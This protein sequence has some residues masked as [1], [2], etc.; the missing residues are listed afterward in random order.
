MCV[1]RVA[2]DTRFDSNFGTP[3]GTF[4]ASWMLSTWRSVTGTRIKSK[5]RTRA[6]WL[7]WATADDLTIELE[8]YKFLQRLEDSV[9]LG[10]FYTANAMQWVI[11]KAGTYKC[12]Q[13]L[14]DVKNVVS[15]QVSL[16]MFFSLFSLLGI[17]LIEYV[18]RSSEIWV[19]GLV[20]H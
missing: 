18:L 14:E 20:L 3:D 10:V 2:Y 19:V 15:K 1:S 8:A 7:G 4:T 6:D 11:E 17:S 12:S 5:A 9:D 16:S 13:G